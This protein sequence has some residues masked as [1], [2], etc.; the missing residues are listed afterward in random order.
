MATLATSLAPLVPVVGALVG[1]VSGL[2]ALI[3]SLWAAVLIV[4]PAEAYLALPEVFVDA[5]LGKMALL[6]TFE[7]D[8]I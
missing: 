5:V 4:E 3:A 6:V 8:L 1:D 2:A 7:A